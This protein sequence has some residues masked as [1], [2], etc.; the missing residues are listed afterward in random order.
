MPSR[1][2]ASEQVVFDELAR[3]AAARYQKRSAHYYVRTKLRMD[4]LPRRLYELGA[5]ERFGSVVDVACGRGQTGILLLAAGYADTLFGI[6]WDAA[7]IA[8]ASEAAHSLPARFEHADVRHA[9]IPSADTVL[10]VDILHYLS[11]D[12]QDALLRDSARAARERVIVRDFDN[13]AGAKSWLTRSWEWTTTIAG[14]NRG[15]AGRAPR[16]F[17]AIEQMLA[18]EGFNVTREQCSAR[19]LSNVLLVARRA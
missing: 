12:E 13:E 9:P 18:A 3:D 2:F 16:P 19:G 8:I 6:D 10:L 14:Y 17:G 1:G 7:K 15:A 5:T 4:P 11:G